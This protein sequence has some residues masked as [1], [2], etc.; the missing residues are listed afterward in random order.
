MPFKVVSIQVDGGSEF[1]RDF[2]ALCKKLGIALSML[3][4]KKSQKNGGVERGNHT[5]REDFSDSEFFILGFI[6]EIR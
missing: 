1:M 2:K 4:P 3:P 5:F 6:A